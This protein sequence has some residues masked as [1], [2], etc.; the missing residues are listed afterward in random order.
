MHGNLPC[1]GRRC[2]TLLSASSLRAVPANGPAITPSLGAKAQ[3]RKGSPGDDDSWLITLAGAGLNQLLSPVALPGLMAQGGEERGE[4]MRF[5]IQNHGGFIAVVITSAV[6]E[7]HKR[8][9]TDFQIP[10]LRNNKM[11]SQHKS[12]LL[13]QVAAVGSLG[14]CPGHIQGLVPRCLDSEVSSV[15]AQALYDLADP[16][17]PATKCSSSYLEGSYQE[18]RAKPMVPG[19]VV[20]FCRSRQDIERFFFPMP[21]DRPPEGC[22]MGFSRTQL[23]KARTTLILGLAGVLLLVGGW[24]GDPHAPSS[25]TAGLLCFQQHTAPR[26]S[27]PSPGCFC[28]L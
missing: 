7:A 5:P 3:Q 8:N 16:P 18:H 27:C 1:Q 11:K 10:D 2:P 22:R 6:S 20:V 19:A 21:W 13:T 15:Q 17:H 12:P 28:F 25:S 23:D 24:S 9:H 4:I 26:H 14:A